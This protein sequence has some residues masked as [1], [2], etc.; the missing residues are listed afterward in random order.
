MV[1]EQVFAEVFLLEVQEFIS[2]LYGTIVRFYMPAVNF[3]IL[4]DLTEDLI[5]IATSLTI[6][7]KL[8]P[9]LMKL[10]RLATREDERLLVE[11][12]YQYDFL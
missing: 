5:E 12:I 4:E 11:K 7:H 6:N 10:C 1:G 9:W 8:S 2:C 3:E